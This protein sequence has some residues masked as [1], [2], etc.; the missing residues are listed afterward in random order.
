MH[1]SKK[2]KITKKQQKKKKKQ[3]HYQYNHPSR[4]CLGCIDGSIV[5]LDNFKNSQQSYSILKLSNNESGSITTLDISE[6]GNF[7]ATGYEY[8]LIGYWDI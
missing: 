2:K 4:I 8:G 5:I 1:I 6:N 3:V 7:I